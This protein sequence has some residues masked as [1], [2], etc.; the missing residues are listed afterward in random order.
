MDKVYCTEERLTRFIKSL[1]S[2][3][4]WGHD[5][6]LSEH[7]KWGVETPEFVHHISTLVYCMSA[8]WC[9]TGVL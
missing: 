8:L 3:C 5:G 9:C 2:G 6:I 4:T 7:L 1:K